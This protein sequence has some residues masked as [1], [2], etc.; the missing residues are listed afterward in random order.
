MPQY[1]S[2]AIYQCKNLGDSLLTTPLVNA[3]LTSEKFS[4][5]SVIC[6][7]ESSVVFDLWDDQI[8]VYDKPR[9]VF[10]LFILALKI[11][12]DLVFLPHRSTLGLVFARFGR[13]VCISE[14]AVS[15]PFFGSARVLPPLMLPWR[16]AADRHLD[17]YR[18]IGGTVR[19]NDRKIH[20]GD[21]VISGDLGEFFLPRSYVVIHPGSRWMFKTPSYSFWATVI[22]ALLV[23]NLKVVITGSDLGEEGLLIERLSRQFQVISLSGK[24]SIK[25][26]A[27]VIAR[28]D[29]YLGV[30]TFATHLAAACGTKGLALYG[31]TSDLIW[32][33]FGVTSRLRVVKSKNYPC[34]PCHAD[35]C[36]GSK[37]SDCLDLLSAEMVADTF[38]QELRRV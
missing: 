6:K 33:P 20:I 8:N 28:S 16:H 24:T 4:K 30:D 27:T 15:I 18:A 2:V 22:K 12:P 34:I 36:G 29:G 32:G 31:P 19:E 23:K 17:L 5:I 13:S 1:K 11:K 9:N 26:L 37:R 3:L 10:G 14:D 38:I 21:L 7:P 35:G 25:Q